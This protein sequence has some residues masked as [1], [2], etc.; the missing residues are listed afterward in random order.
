MSTTESVI[1]VGGGIVGSSLA[2][3]LS[4]S[5][6][7]RSITIIDRSFTSLLGSSGIAPGFI[8]QFNESEVLT[9]LAIDTVSEY[10]KVP[11]GFD[12]VGGLEIAFKDEGIN[13]LKTRC[14]EAEKL[15]LPAAMLSMEEARKLAPDLVK[16][17]A[18]GSALFFSS[19]GTANA[20]KI[21]TWYQDEAR[22]NGVNF[23]EADVQKLSISDGR[24]T[25]VFIKE[26]DTTK[27]LNANKV[28]LTTGIWA[29]GLTSNLEFP[30]PVI[31]VGHPY[32]HGQTRDPQPHKLPFVRW[33]EHHVYCRD[34]G[35]NFGIGS[36]DHAPIGQKPR[37]SATGSWVDWFEQP[38]KFATDLLPP[39]AAD[40]F[41]DSRKF[42]GIFSMT[43]DNMPLAGKVKSIDGLYMSVAVWVTHGAGT[44]KFLVDIIDGKEVDNKTIEALDPE[45]FRGQDFSELEQ[46]SL[47][48]Y[49]SI[50][51]TVQSS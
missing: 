45:R 40:V 7:H 17:S 43:P 51:K 34:H 50:Y 24:I 3:F 33:P 48:G 28:I 49:N 27:Q 12:R 31:P 22:K 4:K 42:N 13:R 36:Y 5:R 46:K 23:V 18:A 16:E 32:M 41:K 35:K 11:G 19:D 21:T 15:G 30:V 37:E 14:K 38:L 6:I 8:G 44:S 25:G 2:Y 9:K 29:Q 26:N 47:Q 20:V 1:I 10:V 39:A